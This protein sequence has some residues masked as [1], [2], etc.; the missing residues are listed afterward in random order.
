MFLI[1]CSSFSGYDDELTWGAIWLYKATGETAYLT[2]AK[3]FWDEFNIGAGAVQ[4]GWDD[5]RAGCYVCAQLN[6]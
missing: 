4:F 3:G 6:I 5:K 2:K 1:L